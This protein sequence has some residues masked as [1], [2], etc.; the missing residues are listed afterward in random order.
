MENKSIVVFGGSF[1]PP[2]NSH[3]SIAQQV[4]NQF[5]EVEKKGVQK[6]IIAMFRSRKNS[7]YTCK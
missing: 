6:Q 1:N 4:L 7:F 3:F 5:T 2:L